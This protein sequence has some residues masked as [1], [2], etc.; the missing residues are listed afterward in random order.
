MGNHD[1]IVYRDCYSGYKPLC[2]WDCEDPSFP[3][4]L[5]CRICTCAYLVYR[6]DHPDRRLNRVPEHEAVR[7]S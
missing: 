4:W 1:C 7:A 6:W 2:E 3:D 5:D